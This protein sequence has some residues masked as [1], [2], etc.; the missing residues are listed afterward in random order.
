M[1]YYGTR[2]KLKSIFCVLCNCRVSLKKSGMRIPR[3]ELNEIGP[4]V[5]FKV[6]R[7]Q[8]ASDDLFKQSCRKPKSLKAKTKKNVSKDELGSTFGRIH[9]GAQNI[10]SIQTRKLKGLKK[11][12]TERKAEKKRKSLESATGGSKKV[13]ITSGSDNWWIS[14]DNANK[15]RFIKNLT[16]QYYLAHGSI[17]IFAQRPR[18]RILVILEK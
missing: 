5:D 17:S 2:L 6:R 12:L 4:S 8:L 9:M 3:I 13:K 15:Y 14:M 7:T 16:V 1:R 18:R 11:T 10:N